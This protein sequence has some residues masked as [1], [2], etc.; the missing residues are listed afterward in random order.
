MF[1][2]FKMLERPRIAHLLHI[3]MSIVHCDTCIH[4][5]L[6]DRE[7]RVKLWILIR[8]IIQLEATL[9]EAQQRVA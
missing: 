3:F 7:G 5:G 9:R 8:G 2:L 4:C 6:Q 1:S